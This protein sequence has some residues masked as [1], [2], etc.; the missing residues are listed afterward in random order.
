MKIILLLPLF[1]MVSC[2]SPKFVEDNTEVG[3]T[4]KQAK[5]EFRNGLNGITYFGDK[6]PSDEIIDLGTKLF[7]ET[8]LSQN[9]TVSCSRCHLPQLHFSDGLEK[10]RGTEDRQAPR[11]AQTVLNTAGQFLQHWIGDR[12]SVEAQA[13]HSFTVKVPFALKDHA[14]LREKLISA[15][16][17]DLFKKAYNGLDIKKSDPKLVAEKTA[18]AIGAYERTLVGPARFDDFLAGNITV[19]DSKELR[20]LKKFMEFGC[21]SCHSGELVGGEMFQKFGVAHDYWKFTGSK[22][23][24]LGRFL[25]TKDENDKYYF[26]VPP[27]RNVIYTAPYFHD[28]SVNDLE[29]AIRIMGKVQLDLDL[30]KDDI[31]D[32]KSFL[33][34]LSTKGEYLE[35]LKV[36]PNLPHK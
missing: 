15:N 27:L 14:E 24:D 19:L 13:I 28:G 1:A 8:R 31:S 29:E 23:V 12:E 10:S 17:R 25:L 35:K 3:N 4:F 5:E 36:V 18:F 22:N 7:F 16:Y 21:S 2:S 30:T 32:L 26:K 34:S 9:G 6:R 20:G 11:N 33:G